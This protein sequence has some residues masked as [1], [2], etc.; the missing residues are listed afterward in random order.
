MLCTCVPTFERH[1]CGGSEVRIVC[2]AG[3][4]HAA[5]EPKSHQINRFSSAL[6][7]RL[8]IGTV[9]GLL[10]GKTTLNSV[11]GLNEPDCELCHCFGG[12]IRSIDWIR[13]TAE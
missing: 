5:S 8:G 4:V 2:A 11:Y 3:L 9:A 1:R 6:D 13:G 10:L 12:V 7:A